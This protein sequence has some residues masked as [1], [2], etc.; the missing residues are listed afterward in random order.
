GPEVVHSVLAGLV[1]GPEDNLN[2][3]HLS[4]SASDWHSLRVGGLV[5]AGILCFL[6]IVILLSKWKQKWRR[7]NS[8]R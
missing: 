4:F 6:G 5:F 2:P 1:G 7:R 8:P 3:Q